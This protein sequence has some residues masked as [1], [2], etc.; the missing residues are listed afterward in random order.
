MN[1]TDIAAELKAAKDEQRGI[2]DKDSDAITDQ[3]E[4]R[5]DELGARVT[6]LEKDAKWMQRRSSLGKADTAV[7]TAGNSKDQERRDLHRYLLTGQY[8]ARSNNTGTDSAGGYLVP[9]FWSDQIIEKVREIGSVM[10]LANVQ[11]IDGT[12]N[13]AMVTTRPTFE[14]VAEGSAPTDSAMV[15]SSTSVGIKTLAGRVPVTRDLLADGIGSFNEAYLQ[16]Q[17][18]IGLSEAMETTMQTGGAASATEPAGISQAVVAG[19]QITAAGAAAITAADV[20]DLYQAIS[21]AYRAN[22]TWL[23]SPAFLD[24][25]RELTSGTAGSYIW[26]V[27]QDPGIVNGYAGQLLGRNVVVST[28]LPALATTNKVAYFGDF[29][30]AYLVGMRG[31]MEI[32]SDPYTLANQRTIAVNMWQRFDTAV[33]DNNAL[34]YLAMA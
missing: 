30:Q 27:G 6:G 29:S 31:G 32:V 16:N 15:F 12:T 18:A 17:M 19:N 10:G 22:S 21:P 20:F 33:L 11:Q 14:Y 28:Y 24:A 5:F 25:V 8:E 3:D 7:V 13:Y 2:A 34:A 1:D 9:S 4:V 23:V 26:T